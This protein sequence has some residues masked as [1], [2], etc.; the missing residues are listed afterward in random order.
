MIHAGNFSVIRDPFTFIVNS[1]NTGTSNSNQF[2]I[3][4]NSGSNYNIKT[5]DGYEAN[6]LTGN[7]TIT[8][9]SGA[10]IHTVEISGRFTGFYFFNGGDK[11]KLTNITKWGI[12][13]VGSTGQNVAFTGCSNMII[14]ATDPTQFRGI[15]QMP[16]MF[17]GTSLVTQ[18]PYIDVSNATVSSAFNAFCVNS[19]LT[20]FL[21]NYFD[22]CPA[23]DFSNSFRNNKIDVQGVD[24]ILT[25]INTARLAGVQISGRDKIIG[26][27]LGTN[28][29]PS[30]AGKLIVD[31]LRA[32]GWTVELNG[33]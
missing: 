15:T 32:D 25:S 22:N 18:I 28:A 9:P 6:S 20:T 16:S 19:G 29:T 27:S 5:S 7:H 12:Y 21:P 13:G 3:P 17:N 1:N 11:L 8:F 31:A 26:L 10:G 14:T 23:T 4:V 2:T 24:N 30:A 33:Y